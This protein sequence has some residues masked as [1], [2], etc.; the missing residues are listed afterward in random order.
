MV[1][2]RV[3]KVAYFGANQSRGTLLWQHVENTVFIID[4][5]IWYGWKAVDMSNLKYELLI[6]FND[7]ILKGRKM[8]MAFYAS[9]I[10]RCVTTKY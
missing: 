3:L 8:K 2:P 7:S 1:A 6:C 5:Y 9:K 4:R 10:V